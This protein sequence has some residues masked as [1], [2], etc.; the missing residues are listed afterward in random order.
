LEK[1]PRY[2]FKKAQRIKGKKEISALFLSGKKWNGEWCSVYFINNGIKRSRSIIIIPKSAGSA[3]ERNRIKR[4]TR[5]SLRYLFKTVTLHVDVLIKIHPSNDAKKSEQGLKK[6][7]S[8]WA[9]TGK[10]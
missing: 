4:Q 10:K 3:V 5:E 1:K 2:T 6:D 7:L 8:L 9:I